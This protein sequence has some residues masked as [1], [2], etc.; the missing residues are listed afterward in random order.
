MKKL[1]SLM[2]G[3]IFMAAACS[4]TTPETFTGK[5]YK[6][7]GTELGVEITLGFAADKPRYFG[8][9]AVNRYFGNYTLDGGNLV[10]GPAG[11]TMMAGPKEMMEA[12]QKY[13]RALGTVKSYK[14]DGKKLTIETTEGQTLVFDE[15]GTVPEDK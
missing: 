4:K 12:E 5:E 15:I 7:T 13:L 2:L 10:F 1:L 9:S 6:L 14:L 8:K 3:T 11:S